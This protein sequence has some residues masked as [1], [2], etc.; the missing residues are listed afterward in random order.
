M[1]NGNEISRVKIHLVMCIGDL[2]AIAS[3]CHHRTHTAHYPCRICRTEGVARPDGPTR[4]KYPS[5]R[6]DSIRPITDFTSP[7]PVSFF[8]ILIHKLQLLTL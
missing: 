5:Q 6:G 4:S 1:S 7:D 8:L 2:P 3:L